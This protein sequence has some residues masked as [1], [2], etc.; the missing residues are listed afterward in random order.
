MLFEAVTNFDQP[1]EETHM[2]RNS[3][4]VALFALPAALAWS[5]AVPAL[6]ELAVKQQGSVSYV[7]GGVG[8]DELQEIKKLVSSYPLELLFVTQGT[9]NQY[10]SGVKVQIK[11]AGG[12]AV[13][14]L[15]A[16]GPVLLAKLPPGRYS[17]SADNGGIVKRQSV[18][19][20]A[21]KPQRIMFVWPRA[22]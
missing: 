19:I 15:E 13:A 7:S 9:P 16:D 21:G 17:I 22:D 8:D 11:D 4:R 6:A 14:D 1:N 12:K 2:N 10:L 3:L 5:L 20:G 18:S